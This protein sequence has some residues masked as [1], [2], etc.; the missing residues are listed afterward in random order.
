MEC[1]ICPQS[2]CPGEQAKGTVISFL[3]AH[4]S[5]PLP[6]LAFWTGKIVD[7]PSIRRVRNDGLHVWESIEALSPRTIIPPKYCN[8]HSHSTALANGLGSM[9]VV[10]HILLQQRCPHL[11]T[12]SSLQDGR[13]STRGHYRTRDGHYSTHRDVIIMQLSGKRKRK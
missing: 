8:S 5:L 12:H 4:P 1:S 6:A 11:I 9:F 7:Y 10:L 3:R 2:Q 13:Y